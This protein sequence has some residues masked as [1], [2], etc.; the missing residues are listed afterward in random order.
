M[1]KKILVERVYSQI[2]L[3]QHNTCFSKKN[4]F[5]ATRFGGCC[6]E[7]SRSITDTIHAQDS[8]EHCKKDNSYML[9]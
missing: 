8:S 9:Q 3:Y 5:C 4:C 7:G 6:Y 1:W 2:S